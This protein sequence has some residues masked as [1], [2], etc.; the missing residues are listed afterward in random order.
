MWVFFNDSEWIETGA[1]KGPVSNSLQTPNPGSSNK[2]YWE[3]HFVA[4]KLYNN[5][6]NQYEYHE[7]A[8]G[9]KN[10]TGTH[11]F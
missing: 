9:S 11:N 4:Y 2:S 10:P 8:Y 3:G 5:S 6:S 7:V 1:T